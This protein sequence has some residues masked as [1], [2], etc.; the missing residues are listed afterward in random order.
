MK[1]EE[2]KSEKQEFINKVSGRPNSDIDI[3]FDIDG[4]IAENWNGDYS[5][6]PPVPEGIEAVNKAYDDGYNITLF[7]A[8]YGKRHPGFQYQYGYEE[9]LTW[10]RKHGVKFHRLIMGKPAG[11]VY[12]DD[13]AVRVD[14]NNRTEDWKQF[15]RQLEQVHNKNYYGQ[16][17][18][19][20]REISQ[21]KEQDDVLKREYLSSKGWE[22]VMTEEDGCETW[23][24]PWA[25]RK[26]R[27]PADTLYRFGTQHYWDLDKAFE[28]QSR[29]DKEKS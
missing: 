12:V 18:I 26:E 25:L 5:K 21:S 2:F 29:L 14:V 3:V 20:S 4:V 27:W 7:T 1:S 10:L 28:F 15:W 13:K 23:R 6:A 19:S 16:Q 9:T 22:Q 11:D 24:F 17:Q 8:R